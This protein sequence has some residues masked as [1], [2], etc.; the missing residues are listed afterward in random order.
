M[1]ISHNN[2]NCPHD[3][4]DFHDCITVNFQKDDPLLQ[5]AIAEGMD[6]AGKVNPHD[7]GDRIRT[8][9]QIE[10]R[11]ICGVLAELTIRKLLKQEIS[12]RKI[13]AKLLPSHTI[14]A[15]PKIGNQ[16]DIPIIVN[17]QQF[18]IEVRS[19]F[20]YRPLNIV[21]T[22]LF[23]IIGWYQSSNKLVEHAKDYYLRVLYNFNESESM[24]YINSEINLHF[25]G[26][27][28]REMLERLGRWND[29]DQPGAL[30]RSIKPICAAL[31]T[32]QIMDKIFS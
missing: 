22:H 16:I 3:E 2:P 5:Q 1:R 7:T 29:F 21:I 18:D 31:D 23:D 32:K 12:N 10:R 4:H 30:Y 26:G 25:V 24:N 19:S 6:L 20:P 13:D 11:C 9:E 15:G 28:T 17:G 14:T 8:A 27:A